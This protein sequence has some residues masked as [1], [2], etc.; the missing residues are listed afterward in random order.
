MSLSFVCSLGLQFARHWELRPKSRFL[1]SQESGAGL[2]TVTPSHILKRWIAKT[3]LSSVSF[4][5]HSARRG[6]ATAAA[7]RGVQR[8]LLMRHGNWR[9]DAVDIYIDDTLMDRL[10]VTRAIATS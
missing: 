7:A 3:G 4:S 5:S 9:S 1:F 10:S 6:G 8:R 2:A